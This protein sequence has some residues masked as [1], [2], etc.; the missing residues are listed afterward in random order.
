MTSLASIASTSDEG[1]K[2][3]APEAGGRIGDVI[4]GLKL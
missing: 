4:V 1:T 3:A 2:E